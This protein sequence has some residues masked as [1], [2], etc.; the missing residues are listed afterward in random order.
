MK[1]S[2]QKG[3]LATM[4]VDPSYGNN[5]CSFTSLEKIYTYKKK[6]KKQSIKQV[7][8]CVAMINI[9]EHDGLDVYLYNESYKRK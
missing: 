7:F 9:S 8:F 3:K 4:C 2:Q 6:K 5:P 1:N